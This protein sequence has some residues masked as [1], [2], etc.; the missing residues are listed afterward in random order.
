MVY[1]AMTAAIFYYAFNNVGQ[2]F[3]YFQ[4]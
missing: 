4:F 2:E 1:L 3:I